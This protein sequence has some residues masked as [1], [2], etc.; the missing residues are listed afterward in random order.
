MF[1]WSN[2]T[3]LFRIHIFFL[4]NNVSY[5]QESRNELEAGA[6]NYKKIESISNYRHDQIKQKE[7]KNS[8]STINLACNRS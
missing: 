4:F 6:N 8:A 2:E 7:Q 1:I 3:P 5:S